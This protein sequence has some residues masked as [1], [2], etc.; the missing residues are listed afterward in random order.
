MT[1]IQTLS[2]GD[3]EL[4]FEFIGNA[5]ELSNSKTATRIVKDIAEDTLR[6]GACSVTH[7]EFGRR[8]GKCR[9]TVD[10]AFKRL[11][12]L[13][14]IERIEKTADGRSTYR[15]ILGGAYGQA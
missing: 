9:R 8:T 4:A 1:C 2:E 7:K 10:Y 5:A 15:A 11:L 13:G 14:L 3:I 12:R 6:H